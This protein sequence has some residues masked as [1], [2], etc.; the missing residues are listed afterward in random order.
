MGVTFLSISYSYETCKQILIDSEITLL[1]NVNYILELGLDI[2]NFYEIT[3]MFAF[4]I[5]I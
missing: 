2:I 3:F 4:R 1:K 5:V